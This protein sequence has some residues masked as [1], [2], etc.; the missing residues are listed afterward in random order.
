VN[1]TA[2]TNLEDVLHKHFI[3]SLMVAKYINLLES[4]VVDVGTGAGFPGIPLKILTPS[5][6][7]TL[8]DSLKKR[9]KFLNELLIVLN[10]NCEILHAAAQEQSKK[11]DKGCFNLVVSRAAMNVEKLIWASAAFLKIGGQLVALKGYEVEQELEIATS[12]MQKSKLEICSVN[13]FLLPNGDRRS[14]V[15]FKKAAIE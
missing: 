12:Q 7:L 15:V 13:K 9:V 14:I 11:K 5:L 4:K 2:I 8:L 1:L 3:D 10:I 6:N